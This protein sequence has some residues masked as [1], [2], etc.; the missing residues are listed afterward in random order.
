MKRLLSVLTAMVLVFTGSGC[1]IKSAEEDIHM[2]IDKAQKILDEMTLEEK[3]GQMFFARYPDDE[4]AWLDAKEYNLGGYILFSKDFKDKTPDEVKSQ[5]NVCQSSAKIPMFIGVDEEGGLVNRIS[6]HETL[7]PEPFKSPQELFAEGG[8]ELI[9]EDTIQ[10][11]ILLNSLGININLAPVCDVSTDK[12]AFIYD[13]TFGDNAEKT[14]EYVK[15]VVSQMQEYGI[16]SCLKHFPGYGNNLDTHTDIVTDTRPLESYWNNDFIPF[17]TGIDN[18]AEIIMVGHIIVENID[19][20]YPASLSPKVHQILRED[21]NFDGLI[22]TDDLSMDAVTNYVDGV[23]A[24]IQAIKAGNDLICCTNYYVKIPA[25]IEAVKKGD[26]T[27]S[28]INESVKRILDTKIKL[29][30]IE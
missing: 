5:I 22:M 10:K 7:T 11:C 4:T 27:E 14:S 3:V 6:K 2:E 13:R 9:K 15:T 18:G 28:R 26:I 19:K 16:G 20:K 8:Y 30:L 29:G 23:S 17:Q 24:T 1:K 12:S 21:L 25:V